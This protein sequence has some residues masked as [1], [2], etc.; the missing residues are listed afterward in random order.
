MSGL[1]KT[2]M[3]RL[4]S[5]DYTDLKKRLTRRLGS[6]DLADEAM[7]DAWIRLATGRTDREIARPEN[8]LFRTA[9]NAAIDLHRK[10]KR[11][12]RS[13]ELDL[14]LEIPDDKPTPEE[15]MIARTEIDAF[16]TIVS[17]LPARQRAIFLAAR[18]GNIPHD[19]IAKQMRITRR[20]VARELVRAHEYCLSR[21]KELMG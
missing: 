11:H 4:F 17:E 15:E 14:A 9:L 10:E 13:V 1:A 21:C 18:V 3:R 7:H 16:E 6:A 19:V 12:R 5:E 8:Y 2:V 20:T